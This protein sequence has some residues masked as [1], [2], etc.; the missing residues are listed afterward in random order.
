MKKSYPF[1]LFAVLATAVRA[2]NV[3]DGTLVVPVVNNNITFVK[4]VTLTVQPPFLGD[5]DMTMQAV[6]QAKIDDFLSAGLRL[7]D[8]LMRL[9]NQMWGT[10]ATETPVRV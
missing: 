3:S 7:L 4:E 5:E 1:A 10:A 2:F 6:N 9:F 8:P